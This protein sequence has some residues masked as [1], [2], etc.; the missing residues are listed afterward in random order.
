MNKSIQRINILC[1]IAIV[2]VGMS[3]VPN[4]NATF[5]PKLADI[6]QNNIAYSSEDIRITV[7][8]DEDLITIHYQ[9]RE[10][11]IKEVTIEGGEFKQIILDDE[12]N[13]MLKGRPGL[14]NICRSV[15]I[16]D[17][18]R[19]E[20]KVTNSQYEEYEGM[21]LPRSKQRGI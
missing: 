2:L 19:M 14:P 4:I 16:P 8:N 12:S 7:Q 11:T 18:L 1:L 9:I 21:K 6:T 10:F 13:S 3:V 5:F 17:N 15:I 20:I